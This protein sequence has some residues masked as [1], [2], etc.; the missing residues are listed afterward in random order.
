MRGPTIAAFNE[1]YFRRARVGRDQIQ[2]LEPFFYPLDAVQDWNRLY[3]RRG[4]LQYQF[5][6]PFG[7]EDVLHDVLRRLRRS[8]TRTVLGVLKRFGPAAGMLSFAAPGW[9]LALDVALPSPDLAATLDKADELVAGAGGRVYLAKDSRLRRHR[10]AEMYPELDRWREVQRRLDL[11]GRMQSDL[12]RRIG[13]I[14]RQGQP[15][16]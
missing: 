7:A 12:A 3:G 14:D 8:R 15:E 5:V 11:D 10:I 6:V 16:A 4:F 2:G 1:L 13:L 9:T